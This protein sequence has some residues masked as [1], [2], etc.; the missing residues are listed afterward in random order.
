MAKLLTTQDMIEGH[1]DTQTLKEA[2]NEDKMITSRL[3]KEF[4]SVP[5]ASRLFVES[6]L[7][8]ATPYS[9]FA[10]MTTEGAESENGSYAVVTND[11][12]INNIDKNGFYEK[13]DGDWAF[14]EWNPIVQAKAYTNEKTEKL[15]DINTDENYAFSVTDALDRVAIGVKDDGTVVSK[16]ME[17]G[18]LKIDNS[19]LLSDANMVWGV[20]DASDKTAIYVDDQGVTR[21][22][23]LDTKELLVNGKPL[24]ASLS[25]KKSDGNYP[26]NINHLEIFGQSLSIG[27]YSLPIQTTTQEYDSL[28]F[29]GGLRKQHPAYD[30]PNFYADFVPLVEAAAFGGYVGY[31]TPCGGATD[32]VKQ[33]V[34]SENGVT[35]TQQ[36]YQMLGS[37]SG[38][39]GR[40]IEQLTDDFIDANLK[41][42][43][44]AAYNL[45][46]TKGKTYAMPL[47]GWV[48]GENNN[49][50]SDGTTIA[51]YQASLQN[52]ISIV[53]AHLKTLN[54]D[55]A[56]DGV[57]TTQLC[58]FSSSGRTE[59]H[60]ELAIYDAVTKPDTNV[61]FA[62]PLY[63]F[64]YEDRYH[65]NG[66]SSKWM[67]A[68]IGLAY[69]RLVVDGVDWRPLHPISN[70]RQGKIIEVKFHVPVQP[71]VFDTT[72]VALNTN[73]GFTLVDESG[74]AIAITSVEITQPDT[75]KIIADTNIPAGAELRY[76]W[77][78][79][80]QPNRVNG[81]R[82]NLRDSQGND[83][84][85]DQ[86][87]I[88]KPLH[89][90]T[91]IFKYE[92]A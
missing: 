19:V 83:I 88:N 3:G 39:G 4:A 63:I 50:P 75:V 78:P 32:A 25:V 40:S 42:T 24:G 6:G 67:G 60:I 17:T 44:T 12:I 20:T 34:A 62:C 27:A 23:S 80:A 45:A 54:S 58:S 30:V 10:K 59:P 48:Q 66:I 38:Q 55:L 28:M 91:P 46:Q 84:V 43:I 41:P 86:S 73:Y 47:M 13:I 87:G 77:T 15:K 79:V 2:V 65:L 7:L 68:Y 69:K 51:G 57:I 81:P 26:A 71:L 11:P 29:T 1:L 36:Q 82:G 64:D 85:F 49:R 22:A 35:Y 33:L 21:T 53:D 89:N 76:A 90:W 8:G 70:T 9:T 52:I 56:L 5:M 92:V 61:Y 16:A 72:Q 31:E 18:S 14:L 74:A 37:A